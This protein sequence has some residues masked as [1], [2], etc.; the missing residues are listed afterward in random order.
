MKSLNINGFIPTDVLT[1]FQNMTTN[2]SDVSNLDSIIG[3]NSKSNINNS[4]LD[5]SSILKEKLNEVNDKQ[6]NADNITNEFIS[7]DDID[8]HQVMLSA[9]EAQMSLQLAV[10]MRNKIVESYQELNRMQV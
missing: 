8:V 3:D 10:Q 4:S 1:K 7:G 5:F 6:I 2:S 9:Q